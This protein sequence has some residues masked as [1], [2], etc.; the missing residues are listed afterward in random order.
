[1]NIVDF[2]TARITDDEAMA[3]Q[4]DEDYANT[5]L[6]PT[7]DSDHQASWNTERVLAECAAKRAIVA[8]WDDPSGIDLVTSD[9]DAGSTLATDE[10]VRALAAVYKY[11]PDYQQEWA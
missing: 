10:A 4:E 3:R 9:V 5:T 11:H 7:Y 1:M 8:H 2:L 6:L